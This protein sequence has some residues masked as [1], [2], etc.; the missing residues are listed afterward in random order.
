M[1]VGTSG[2]V[3]DHWRGA[4]YPEDLPKSR[5][6]GHYADRFDT[7]EINNTYYQLAKEKAVARWA[8]APPGFVYVFKARR[9]ITHH[10][11][12]A[13]AEEPLE[14][15]FGAL[16][17]LRERTACILFQLPENVKRARRASS[18]GGSLHSADDAK[19][20]AFLRALPDGWRAAFEFRDRSWFAPEVLDILG[21]HGA[22]FCVHDWP[23][24]RPVPMEATATLAYVRFHG[25]ERA[26][27][28]LYGA[29][30]LAPW[31]KR[32]EAWRKGK[33]DVLVY[34]NNDERAYAARDAAWMQAK[35]TGDKRE[36]PAINTGDV[37]PRRERAPL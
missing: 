7:V 1:R 32:I 31:L 35:L 14:K 5:W 18:V 29:R 9:Y 23:A 36:L 2:Y 3:Y 11:R 24:S 30:R 37:P 21:E 10:R 19:L 6:F 20:R 22:A 28:G 34:F 27:Q 15:F 33:H 16:K 4:F 13:R 17:P 26:Y 12:L 25:V 8:D